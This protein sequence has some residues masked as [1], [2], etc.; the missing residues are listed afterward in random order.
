MLRGLHTAADSQRPTV[1]GI[2]EPTRLIIC[3]DGTYCTADGPEGKGHGNTSNVYRLFA[4]IK[5]GKC[6]D[7]FNQEKHY[8][9]GIGSADEVGS[10]KRLTAGVCGAGYQDFI[11]KSYEQCCQLTSQDEI[12]LFGF[13]RGAYIARAVAGLLDY[14]GALNS[15]GDQFKKDYKKML[16]VYNNKEK[17]SRIGRGQVRL[18]EVS[19][20]EAI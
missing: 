11:Q 14:I 8:E 3:I 15:T 19:C 12:W 7:G 13:S 9:E 10:L 4:S 6:P 20:F 16:E 17:R 1:H 2:Q 18:C 5:A